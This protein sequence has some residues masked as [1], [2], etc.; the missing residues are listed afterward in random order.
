M[1]HAPATT[2][3]V[4]EISSSTTLLLLA[5]SPLIEQKLLLKYNNVVYE[6]TSS[7]NSQAG[8]V[9]VVVSEDAYNN[10]VTHVICIIIIIKKYYNV[11][12]YIIH[13][14]YIGNVCY[15]DARAHMWSHNR[16]RLCTNKLLV[17]HVYRYIQYIITTI[18]Q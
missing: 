13:Y 16:R 7:T 8:V 11:V 18:Y 15:T 2:E 1:S 9:A 6:D 14:T 4:F 17:F 10:N 3:F 12:R 5:W